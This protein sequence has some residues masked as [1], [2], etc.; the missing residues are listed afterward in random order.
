L[1]YLKGGKS[2]FDECTATV[3]FD[4][5]IN[6]ERFLATCK[7]KRT[8]QMFVNSYISSMESVGKCLKTNY[9]AEIKPVKTLFF[10]IIQKDF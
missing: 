7:Q 5:K 8:L 1:P 6:A 2:Q 3:M 9:A 10:D 4:S